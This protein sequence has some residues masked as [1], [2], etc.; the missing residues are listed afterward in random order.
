LFK[1]FHPRINL[2]TLFLTKSYLLNTI[3]PFSDHENRSLTKSQKPL[4]GGYPYEPELKNS[5][6]AEHQVGLNDTGSQNFSSQGLMVLAV[7]DLDLDLESL[8]PC[9][10]RILQFRFLSVATNEMFFKVLLFR[11]L[12]TVFMA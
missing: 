2:A 8:M 4:Q 1:K 10:L 9:I 7:G 5:E 3:K 6:Y 11:S 12:G